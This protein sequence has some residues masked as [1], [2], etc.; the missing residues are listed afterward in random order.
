MSYY[1]VVFGGRG[2]GVVRIVTRTVSE[3][4][5]FFSRGSGLSETLFFLFV[6]REVKE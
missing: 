1:V 2:G 3:K 6:G 4:Y 5:V